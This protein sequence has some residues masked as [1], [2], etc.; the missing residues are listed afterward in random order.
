MCAHGPHHVHAFGD[1]RRPGGVGDEPTIDRRECRTPVYMIDVSSG[2]RSPLGPAVPFELDRRPKGAAMTSLSRTLSL[3]I[4]QC[5]GVVTD[6]QLRADG[7]NLHVRRRLVT[8]GVLTQVTRACTGSHRRPTRSSPVVSRLAWPIPPQ[9][10]PASPPRDCGSS[11]TSA[12]ASNRSYW[13]RTIERRSRAAFCYV[14]PIVST[15]QRWSSDRTA[16]ASPVHRELG[17]TAPATSTTRV[18]NSS[19]SGSSISTRP[20]RLSGA[21]SGL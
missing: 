7:V 5:H 10:S 13:S 2:R 6:A 14:G 11:T 18:S 16:F 17:S 9:S 3:Q 21:R 4:S 20:F 12:A 19:R 8:D 1:W 15:R